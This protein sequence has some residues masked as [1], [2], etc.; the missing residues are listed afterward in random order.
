MF[1]GVRDEE[2]HS[3]FH[4]ESYSEPH[5]ESHVEPHSE[6]HSESHSESQVEVD[7]IQAPSDNRCSSIKIHRI[8]NSSLLLS[9][10][11]CQSC[12]ILEFA[13]RPGSEFE[14]RSGEVNG[15]SFKIWDVE[16]S[17]SG[18]HDQFEFDGGSEH[19]PV[20]IG[21]RLGNVIVII[22]ISGPKETFDFSSLTKCRL[23]SS[24]HDCAV[25]SVVSSCVRGCLRSLRKIDPKLIV[26]SAER[27][28]ND[29]K[30]VHVDLV[31][32]S[33][34][35]IVRR[36]AD[37]GWRSTCYRKFGENGGEEMD[38]EMREVGDGGSGEGGGEDEDE[39]DES[40]EDEEASHIS[41]EEQDDE[42]SFGKR[43]KEIIRSGFE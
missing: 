28:V 42:A 18:V 12:E 27:R 36:S 23:T 25:G 17:E 5:S 8:L 33:I 20:P 29:R 11:E 37:E 32:N 30:G 1:T 21:E 2:F 19:A 22:T 43:M 6:P 4:S 40:Q 15:S 41:W 34:V 35:S 13:R 10:P 14:V 24:S 39:D 38:E 16:S 7:N 26:S 3:E 31:V 9:T